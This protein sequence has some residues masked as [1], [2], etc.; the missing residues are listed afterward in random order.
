MKK[1]VF[2]IS[3]FTMFV[4]CG[5]APTSEKTETLITPKLVASVIESNTNTQ[6]LS[7]ETI[8]ALSVIV[9]TNLKNGYNLTSESYSEPSERTIKLAKLTD[10][11]FLT[12]DT[13]QNQ[14]ISFGQKNPKQTFWKKEIQK[15]DI[16][17]FLTSQKLSLASLSNI[18]PETNDNG[19]TESLVVGGKKINF[20]ILKNEFNLKSNKISNIENLSNSV[21]ITGL[22]D[23]SEFDFNISESENLSKKGDDYKNLIK[24]QLKNWCF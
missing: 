17:K 8:K 3:I 18:E 4:F 22:M 10:Y 21:I 16:L 19:E 15:S 13:N 2:I 1:L 12:D 23:C 14:Y 5:C 20:E 9:R 24:K 6:N 11:E 7:D